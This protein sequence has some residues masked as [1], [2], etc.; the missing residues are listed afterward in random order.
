[1]TARF[2]EFMRI[3]S[4]GGILLVFA[5]CAAMIVANTPLHTLYALLIDMPV[6]LRIGPL[7]IAKPL[8]LWINDGMMAVFFFVVGLELKREVL[9]GNLSD[10]RNI[11]LPA[12]GAIGGMLLPALIYLFFNAADPVALKTLSQ[13]TR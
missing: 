5:A 6:D 7:H 8:L 10:A 9:E 11:V 3:E 2:K 12:L 4:I 1:M 13:R